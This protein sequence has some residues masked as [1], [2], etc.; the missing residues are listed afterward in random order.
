M[1]RSMLLSFTVVAALTAATAI[2][3]VPHESSRAADEPGA[4]RLDG[5]IFVQA[6]GDNAFT[7][8][9]V[10]VRKV[11][12]RTFVFGREI[13]DSPHMITRN[14]FGGAGIWVPIDD[15]KVLVDLPPLPAK[16]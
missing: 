7:L 13:T 11:G 16:K 4:V 9:N 2:F 5:P 15:V 3:V 6:E 1:T 10:E 8:D 14:R 12:N